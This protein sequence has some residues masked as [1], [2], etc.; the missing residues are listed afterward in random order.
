MCGGSYG[1]AAPGH[2]DGD[3]RTTRVCAR[4]GS[5]V[6]GARAGAALAGPGRCAAA[7]AA[8]RTRRGAGILGFL[9]AAAMLRV[10]FM[11]M[12]ACV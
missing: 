9:R 5:D 12:V 6:C 7:A 10:R 2:A 1:L 8:G 4:R 3:R 11:V